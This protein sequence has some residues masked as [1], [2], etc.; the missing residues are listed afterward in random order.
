[1]SV[2]HQ[3]TYTYSSLSENS[4]T[5][6]RLLRLLSGPDE[7]IRCSLEDADLSKEPRFDCLSYTWGD[8]LYHG[9]SAPKDIIK[10][11]G[12]LECPINCDGLVLNITSNLQEALLRFTKN[13][14]S[15]T[16]GGDTQLRREALI[17]IDAVC[18]NQKD[19]VEKS[20]Q[21]AMMGKI[22]SAAQSVIIWLGV[23]DWD[24]KPAI[25]V[26]N[27]LKS[28]PSSRLNVKFSDIEDEEVYDALGIDYIEPQ[29]WLDYAAFLQ[30][31]W[32]GRIWVVQEAF[33]AR[34]IIVLCG[35]H[36]LHW[37]DITACSKLLRETNLGNLLMEKAIRAVNQDAEEGVVY[38][39]NTLTNQYILEDM[40]EKATSTKENL[41]DLEGLLS[42]SRKFQATNP[43][44]H[45]FALFGVWERLLKGKKISAE[46]EPNYK[47]NLGTIFANAAWEMIR[48]TKDLNVLS[49]V[50]DSSSQGQKP[51][52]LPSWVPDFSKGCHPYPLSENPR[53]TTNLWK[54]SDGLKWNVPVPSPTNPL[55]LPV[56]GI[57]FSTI[58]STAET[59]SSIAS[60]HQLNS[61]LSLL[62]SHSSSPNA[63]ESF[64]RTLIKDT[65]RSSRPA[66]AQETRKAFRVRI[67]VYIWELQIAA[68]DSPSEYAALLTST[69]TTISSLSSHAQ[70]QGL[71]PTLEEIERLIKIAK[72]DESEKEKREIDG[73]CNDMHEAFRETYAGRRMFATGEG[74]GGLGIVAEGARVR[75]EVWVLAGADVPFVLREG[76][77][78]GR[79]RLVGEAFVCGVMGGEVVKGGKVERIVLE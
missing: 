78:K 25:N 63:F 11:S 64:W 6:I 18:I 62:L 1:M 34:K 43:K 52:D 42:Y 14:F 73:L 16:T 20:F 28:V 31:T 4:K 59:Y 9:L 49:L 44:D 75:D 38:A 30:R 15:L 77:E 39:S 76:S 13:E 23:D 51:R 47:L 69:N 45:I 72:L 58:T 8:P 67:A 3:Q 27:L 24:T 29:D 46:M 40:R 66:P 36:I 22:Y 74:K 68:R 70:N 10:T 26:M 32:F 33:M 53:A 65:F 17:W 41:L 21:V 79:R 19:D 5:S 37:P 12:E 60:K 61:I 2:P 57:H 48:E 71:I 56:E 35:S 55:L 7:P 50:E 54:A